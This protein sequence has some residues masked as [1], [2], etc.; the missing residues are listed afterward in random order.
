MKHKMT[1]TL[2]MAFVLISGCALIGAIYY[3]NRRLKLS[4]VDVRTEMTEET[5]LSEDTSFVT[6]TTTE[7]TEIAKTGPVSKKQLKSTRGKETGGPIQKKEDASVT[8]QPITTEKT[9]AK[10]T[11][12]TLATLEPSTT[13]TQTT[14][15]PV[16]IPEE[17]TTAEPHR[18]ETTTTTTEEQIPQTTT[19]AATTT[20]TEETTERAKVWHPEVTKKVWVV[21]EEAWTEVIEYT[22]YE[23][24]VICSDCGCYLDGGMEVIDNHVEQSLQRVR[25]GEIAMEEA[26]LGSYRIVSVPVPKTE[27]ID[28]PEQGHWETVV[29]TEGFW[30]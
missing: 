2:I 4:E 17:S 9:N 15:A 3:P 12:E 1:I 23:R 24:H 21:D 26:C 10:V 16:Q 14:E 29:I 6:C 5:V 7:L 13:A 28:H 11:T 19:E 22:D 25:N 27:Y 18:E 30:E 8:E 20:T